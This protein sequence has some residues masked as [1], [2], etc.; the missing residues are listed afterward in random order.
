MSANFQMKFNK[1]DN[2]LYIRLSG[3]FD[4]SSACEL[5][6]RLNENP[7]EN[8]YIVIDTNELKK[9]AS[10]AAARL[11]AGSIPGTCRQAGCFLKVLQGKIWPQ[12]VIR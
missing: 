4:G 1:R 10:L 6:N 2:Y 12:T 7:S 5:L 11:N 9:N 3:D 8:G